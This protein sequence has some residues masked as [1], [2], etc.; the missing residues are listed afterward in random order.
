M[1]YEFDPVLLT[2]ADNQFLLDNLG[3][4]SIV[5]LRNAPPAVLVAAVKPILDRVNELMELEK[6][7]G[8]QWVGVEKMKEAINT[9]FRENTK[10]KNDHIRNKRAPRWPS[11]YSY[12]S[13]G[14]PHRSGPGS[15]SGR[16]RTYFKPDGT[17]APFAVQLVTD[18]RPE[19][20][21]PGFTEQSTEPLLK[22]DQA[23]HRIECLVPI[24]DGKFCGHA[25][26]FK[27]D[28]RASYNAAR[29]RMSKHLRKATE[30]VEA[31]R[32]LHTNEFGN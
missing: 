14:R 3:K 24:A 25:E 21:A 19:W 28:S 8:F 22:I 5:A 23:S 16:V 27:I 1:I 6:H 26:T 17:R 20:A 18:E 15:D 7:E 30:S 12:D 31:H 2:T 13:K 11:L 9:W 32:E 4:P 10:W 29:A